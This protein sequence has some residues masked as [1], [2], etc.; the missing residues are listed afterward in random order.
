MR[1]LAAF[2]LLIGVL[3]ALA[4]DVVVLVPTPPLV[5]DGTTTATVRLYVDG[6]SYPK[7]KVKSE[8]G[9]VGPVVSGADGVVTFPFTPERAQA[10]GKATLV[11]TYGSA[12]DVSVDVPIIPPLSGSLDVS[13]DPP[14]ASATGSTTVKITPSSGSPITNEQRRF[15]LT[16]SLGTVGPVAPTGSGTWIARY[17]PP[18]GMASPANVVFTAADAAAPDTIVGHGVLPVTLKRSVGFDAPAGTNNLLAVGGRTYGP[19]PASPSGKVAFELE[20]D[21]RYPTGTLTTVAPGGAKTDKSVPMTDAGKSQ[22]AFLTMGPVVLTGGTARVRVAVFGPDGREKGDATVKITASTG[23]VGEVRYTDGAYEATYNTPAAATDATLS[24]E[25]DGVKVDRKVKVIAAPGSITLVAEPAEIPATGSSVKVTARLKDAMG[26]ALKGKTPTFTVISGGTVSGTPRDNG[27]GSYTVTVTV[28]KGSNLLRVAAAPQATDT[29][30][31]ATRLVAWLS[32]P[33]LAANG[34]DST[35]L[36]VLALTPYGTPKPD[37]ALTL[38]VPRGDGSVAASASTGPTGLARVTYKAGKTAGLG[39]IHIEGAG[40]VTDVPVVQ[41]AGPQAPSAPAGGPPDVESA[42]ARWS[43]SAPELAIIR[44]GTA[45]LSGP[46]ATVQISTVPPYTT[47]GAAIQVT[48]RVADT[49]GKG[50]SGQKVAVTAAP[51]TVGAITDNHDGSYVLAVQLPAG[52][53]GPFAISAGVGAI[54]GTVTLPTLANAATAMQRP[55]GSGGGATKATGG[56]AGGGQ[57]PGAPS[58]Q[59]KLR[60]GVL[61]SNSR[62]SYEQ[63]G[64]AG[65]QLLGEATYEAPGAGFFGLDA[66]M[67]YWPLVADWGSIGVDAHLD[68]QLELFNVLDGNYVNLQRDAWGGLR[69]RY[70]AGPVSAVGGLDVHYTTGVLFRY[71]DDTLT[72]AMLLNFPLIGG[73]LSVG[74]ALEVGRSYA[75][76]ELAETF[77]PYPVDTH[78]EAT[79]EYDF[80]AQGVRVGLGWDHRSMSF[81]TEAGDGEADVKQ[82]QISVTAG[83]GFKF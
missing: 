19:L 47:P 16:A 18:K 30:T 76:I 39:S 56:N 81:E 44:A 71:A 25:V 10:T 73:R 40:L 33:T 67:L 52:T 55:A 64:N 6:T 22:P 7:V 24:A 65:G 59:A 70:T 79:Y 58:D 23:T 29:G 42:L 74:G 34:V 11:V 41:A 72:D 20:V 49:T 61:L 63:S 43:T 36:T 4:A 48:V 2:L 1:F 35:T 31:S 78:A 14:L 32:S 17:T 75:V 77:V 38:G 37:V 68:G 13:F 57:A 15:L 66:S 28:S 80:G 54:T 27:D 12:G 50:V 5:A 53:D 69:Y 21:P 62:G 9:K 3:P 8:A 60:V 82:T 51:A 26:V 45:P 83:V 46:P